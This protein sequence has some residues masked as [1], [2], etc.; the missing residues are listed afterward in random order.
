[1]RKILAIATVA[2]MFG[3]CS[4]A[5]KEEAIKIATIKAV[6]DSIRLDSFKR[7]DSEAKLQAAKIKEEKRVL[8][9]AEERAAEN[10]P[11][12]RIAEPTVHSSASNSTSTQNTKKKGWSSAALGTV[13]GAGAGGLGG[14]LI[15]K[16]KGRGAAIG[17]VAGAGAGYLIGRGQDKKSGRAN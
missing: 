2:L 16:K 17:G 5:K 1:M 14:A 6:K 8:M 9:L 7:A 15:D 3:A 12:A 10:A 11:A 13:I 4:N